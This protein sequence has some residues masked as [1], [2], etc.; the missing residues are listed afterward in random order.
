MRHFEDWTTSAT[1][2]PAGSAGDFRLV[3]VA[4]ARLWRPYWGL[5]DI[6]EC[7]MSGTLTSLI[8]D[9][10]TLD[11]MH[12][13]EWMIDDPA[14]QRVMG[15]YAQAAKGRVL[16]GGLG[17]GLLAHELRRNPRV[18]VVDVIEQSE[19][20][21]ALVGPSVAVPHDV[22]VLHGDFWDY[23][24]V[25]GDYDTIIVDLWDDRSA[26]SMTT[27][28]I[29]VST[30]VSAVRLANPQAMVIVHGFPALSDYDPLHPEGA[31][32]RV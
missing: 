28:F 6:S 1:A 21:I 17:L 8:E 3:H 24:T 31:S 16:V 25:V 14:R 2:I 27:M 22:V 11:T 5:D 13:T 15:L 7:E 23:A 26:M 20:V 19:D 4:V 30:K 32:H 10:H 9:Q 12:H 29:D 18:G